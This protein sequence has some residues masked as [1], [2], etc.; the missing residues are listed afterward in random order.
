MAVEESIA[1]AQAIHAA[2]LQ[3]LV[4]ATAS[5]ILQHDEDRR[6]APMLDYS[7]SPIRPYRM[8]TNYGSK[9][10][11]APLINKYTFGVDVEEGRAYC[12][13]GYKCGTVEGKGR[14]DR[15]KAYCERNCGCK[16]EQ[17]NKSKKESN[18][19]HVE[20]S[21]DTYPEEKEMA[22]KGSKAGHVQETRGVFV[23]K[24]T[25]QPPNPLSSS[26][27]PNSQKSPSLSGT[28]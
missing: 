22:G 3:V 24:P 7:I 6:L 8:N 14:W 21:G 18:A 11:S 16:R 27:P 23:G 10:Q 20:E 4:P 17:E 28:V 9:C 13:G 25:A 19:K 26:S 15:R 5:A 2:T 1:I 12:G